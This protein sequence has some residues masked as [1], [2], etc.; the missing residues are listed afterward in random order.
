MK[1]TC[2]KPG[3]LLLID[4]ISPPFLS[5]QDLAPVCEGQD[6][7]HIHVLCWQCWTDGSV[8]CSSEQ[9]PSPHGPD[10]ERLL[11]G[12]VSLMTISNTSTL[13]CSILHIQYSHTVYNIPR[14]VTHFVRVFFLML[15]TSLFVLCQLLARHLNGSFVESVS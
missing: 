4:P 11:A 14:R 3:V 12:N 5:A 15:I 6:P 2:V 13:R 8:C 9:D 1:V 7:L 10:D